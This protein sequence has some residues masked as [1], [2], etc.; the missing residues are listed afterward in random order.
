MKPCRIWEVASE[1]NKR[2][3]H[4]GQP[5]HSGI[6]MRSKY[7]GVPPSFQSWQFEHTELFIVVHILPGPC[8]HF[9][10]KSLNRFQGCNVLHKTGIPNRTAYSVEAS[11][12]MCREF[13]FVTPLLEYAVISSCLG[14]PSCEGHCGPGICSKIC[15]KSVYKF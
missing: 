6:C 9:C 4:E 1:V 5:D 7:Q 3:R 15:Y 13:S 12:M 8:T 11:Q 10:S 2:V 14:S